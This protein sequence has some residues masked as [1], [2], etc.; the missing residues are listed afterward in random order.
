MVISWWR[1]NSQL[2]TLAHLWPVFGDNY[3]N[4]MMMMA[5]VKSFF[6]ENCSHCSLLIFIIYFQCIRAWIP[7][8]QWT[9]YCSPQQATGTGVIVCCERKADIHNCM[10]AAI[11]V[12]E[13][14]GSRSKSYT[15]RDHRLFEK[16]PS[17][18]HSSKMNYDNRQMEV[19]ND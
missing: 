14:T 15:L 10:H 16:H 1:V 18:D 4:T 12:Y 19:H 13:S 2:F 9:L 11:T 8:E 17:F 6:G 3:H 7:S 5:G